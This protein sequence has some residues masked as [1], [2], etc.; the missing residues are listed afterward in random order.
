M[1]RPAIP[2]DLLDA[3]PAPPIEI[4]GARIA[5]GLGLDVATFRQ[6]MA[7]RKITV[8]CERGTGEDSGF[9]RAS[10]YHGERR[11]RVVV[12]GEGKVVA[13]G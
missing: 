1:P 13:E 10:F 8:L 11:V 9:W 6:L 3:A 4:D 7:D 5:R 12:D 2:I